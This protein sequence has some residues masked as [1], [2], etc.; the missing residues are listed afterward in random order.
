M[1]LRVAFCGTYPKDG[2]AV[3]ENE[4]CFAVDP[5]VGRFAVSDGASR[6]Y[7]SKAW[8]KLLVHRFMQPGPVTP[9]WLTE[10]AKEFVAVIDFASLPWYSQQGMM[11]GSF[12]TLLGAECVAYRQEVD[13]FCVGDSLAILCDT[14]G[15]VAT[16][17]YKDPA[18]FD[19]DPVL[20]STRPSANA[21]VAE[22]GFYGAHTTTWPIQTGQ[23]V[24][25]M[26]DAVAKWTLEQEAAGQNPIRTL[27]E[28]ESAEHFACFV[29][30][31]R[32][33]GIMRRDDSTLVHL[34]AEDTQ[35]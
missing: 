24:F 13:I 20:L 31:A 1:I 17:R 9:Q 2:A 25:L 11:E 30:D 16:W 19:T 8:A 32:T 23:S 5:L 18:E 7:D 35:P 34:K 28:I 6:S 26:T 29:E 3:D 14:T 27:A 4:D 21:F 12:A 22:P 33:T 15:I 10:S